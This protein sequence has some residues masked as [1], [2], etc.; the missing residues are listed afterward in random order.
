MCRVQGFCVYFRKQVIW[1]RAA[2]ATKAGNGKWGDPYSY[3]KTCINGD[4]IQMIV[5]L[6][7]MTLS[8]KINGQAQGIAHKDVDK[9]TY[10]VLFIYTITL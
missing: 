9:D 5:D 3:G 1:I 8:Y 7:Q 4:I 2:R 10:R 6:N